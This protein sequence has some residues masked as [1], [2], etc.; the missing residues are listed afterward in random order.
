MKSRN[1]VVIP[2]IHFR[3]GSEEQCDRAFVPI[4]TMTNCM[5]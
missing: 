1:T 2:S 5:F 4:R 3:A